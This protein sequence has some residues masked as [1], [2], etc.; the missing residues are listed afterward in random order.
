MINVTVLLLD[1]GFLSTAVGPMEVFRC[2]GVLWN[3]LHGEEPSPHFRVTAASF[4]GAAARPGRSHQ[5][6][7]DLCL[8]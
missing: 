4:D 8:G 2:A 6:H 7:P 1:G 3:V 5:S